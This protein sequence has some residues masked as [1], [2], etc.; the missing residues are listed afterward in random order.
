MC[1]LYHVNGR[2]YFSSIPFTCI[3]QVK[4]KLQL[5]NLPD[6]SVLV[7]STNDLAVLSILS[8]WSENASPSASGLS[9][10]AVANMMVVSRSPMIPDT[11]L[12][13]LIQAC[14]PREPAYKHIQY[15]Y[16]IKC[17]KIKINNSQNV[18]LCP[19]SFFNQTEKFCSQIGWWCHK[20]WN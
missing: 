15:M 6:T 4:D 5:L 7:S 12:A 10:P 17:S 1:M 13:A 2:E 14:V 19:N 11:V 8:L 9:V 3:F 20:L 18:S 16:S